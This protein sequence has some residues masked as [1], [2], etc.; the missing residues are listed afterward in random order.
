VELYL[1]PHNTPSWRGAQL[2]RKH[3]DIFTFT[4]TWTE[5]V[6]KPVGTMDL[7]IKAN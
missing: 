4:F 1:D 3:R 2:K 6:L 5:N 7:K